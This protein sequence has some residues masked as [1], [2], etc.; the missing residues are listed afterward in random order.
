MHRFS[1]PPLMLVFSALV[2]LHGALHLLGFAGAFGVFGAQGPL[3]S[4]SKLRAWLWLGAALAFFATATFAILGWRFWSLAALV[5]VVGSELLIV[6]SWRDAKFGTLPNLVVLVP[7]L[8][9]L[10]NLGPNGFGTRFSREVQSGFAKAN[11]PRLVVA[12]DLALLPAAVRRYVEY[13]GAVGKPKVFNFRAHFRGQIR[14]KPDG[15]WMNF[16]AEQYEFFEPAKRIFLIRSS[17]YG[18]PFEALHLY[19]GNDATMQ[20]KLLDLF[21]VADARG[22]EMNRSETVTLFNDICAFAPAA[23]IDAAVEWQELDAHS[24]IGTFTNAGNRISAILSFDP[25]GRL[26]NFVSDDRYQTTDGKVYDKYRWSTPLSDYREH[27]G[28]N[29]SS[30]GE[31]SWSMP[32]GELTYG[33]FELVSIQYNVGAL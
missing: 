15:D 28:R 12:A 22:P 21:E 25:D 13:S 19:V 30:Y 32:D 3:A 14:S 24:V 9:S 33:R 29:V 7:A 16:K 6:S 2:A 5:A 8:I 20:V 17:L 10:I 18:L 26:V 4:I 1:T 11:A 31:A 23:L 27:Q